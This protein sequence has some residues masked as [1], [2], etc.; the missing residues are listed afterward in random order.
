M[1]Q[2]INDKKNKELE[3]KKLYS[4]FK[5]LLGSRQV[6]NLNNSDAHLVLLNEAWERYEAY[7]TKEYKLEKP[8]NL[9]KQYKQL[10]KLILSDLKKYSFYYAYKHWFIFGSFIS[11]LILI[12]YLW[13]PIYNLCVKNFNQPWLTTY[14][15]G[16]ALQGLK[17]IEKRNKDIN[18]DALYA[19]PHRENF[20][21]RYKSCLKIPQN[22]IPEKKQLLI[23][24]NSV[25]VTFSLGSDDG[26]RLLIDDNLVINNWQQQPFNIKEAQY[27]LKK[28]QK[29]TIRI[30][31][32][33]IGGGHE[34]KFN[35]N[36]N[37]S[38]FLYPP[39]TNGNCK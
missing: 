5:I 9:N 31:Y 11:I 28:G 14:Y 2:N 24:D 12:V 34:L 35:D 27:V 10:R 25:L 17:L 30:E 1:T 36:L 22:F 29:Y 16:E 4:I 8:S 13:Q 33:D 37:I 38:R 15:K 18:F 23:T 7:K 32:F 26:S 39:D 21:I 20:S 19:V 3:A 6:K